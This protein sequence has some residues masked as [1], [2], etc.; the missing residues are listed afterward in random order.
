MRHDRYRYCSDR[1]CGATDCATCCEDYD[2]DTY[3]PDDD[4]WLEYDEWRAVV[5][6]LPVRHEETP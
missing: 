6:L 1:T 3:E 5:D 4:D 2:P